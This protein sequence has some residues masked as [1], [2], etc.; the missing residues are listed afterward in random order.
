[1]RTF[2]NLKPRDKPAEKPYVHD[3]PLILFSANRSRIYKWTS[4]QRLISP[5]TDI[6]VGPPERIQFSRKFRIRNE[7]YVQHD[8]FSPTYE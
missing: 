8:F 4:R 6:P 3:L 7:S 2:R 5:E 1:M